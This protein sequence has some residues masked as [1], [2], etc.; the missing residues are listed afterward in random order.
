MAHARPNNTRPSLPNNSMDMIKLATGQFTAPQNVQINPTAAAKPGSRPIKLPTQQPVTAPMKK[1][2]TISPPL[3][4]VP[5][6]MAVNNN[7]TGK[8]HQL[9]SPFSAF[10]IM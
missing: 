5:K 10:K 6:V 1:D 3:K 9:L 7:F 2:G 8:S 4:P